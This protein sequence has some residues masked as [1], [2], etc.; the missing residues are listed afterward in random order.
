MSRRGRSGPAISL[1]AFQDIITSVTAIVIVIAL[2]LALDLVQRKAA[3]HAES[4]AGVAEDLADRIH[5]MQA[6]VDELRVEARRTDAIVKEVAQFSP[7]ELQAEIELLQRT[8]QNLEDEHGKLA[9]RE[10]AWKSREQAV[11][12]AKFDLQPKRV[13]LERV[14]KE[15][16]TLQE[17][18]EQERRED[19][20]VFALPRGF[21]KAGWL[22]VIES[23]AISVAPMGRQSRPIRFEQEGLRL[24]NGTA[25]DAF[26]K[27]IRAGGHQTAYFLLLV[28][29][30]GA[31][32]FD[33][34]D[35]RLS[36]DSIS[37]G[38]D[39]IDARQQILHPERGAAF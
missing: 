7:A 5:E 34:L 30:G 16:R 32:Q 18:I 25:V 15:T 35:G 23:A 22:V 2:F 13:Q 10:T 17:R 26:M 27:W 28:R 6:E 21:N 12:A 38:F 37:H 36:V 24:I 19:R 31:T 1:F 11:L 39:V 9:E 4:A 20:P 3:A 14:E 8:I 33:E 29:P